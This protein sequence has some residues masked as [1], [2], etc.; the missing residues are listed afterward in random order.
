M[1]TKIAI[2]KTIYTSD[3]ACGEFILDINVQLAKLSAAEKALKEAKEVAV[4]VMLERLEVTGQKH[5]AFDFGTFAKS[6]KTQVSFPT[7]DKGGKERA[8]AW[9]QECLDRGVIEFSDL[10]NVQQARINADPVLAIE[11]AVQ[12]YNESQALIDPNFV[13]ISESPFNHFTQTTLSTPRKK[14]G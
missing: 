7:A 9:L 8:S 2:P 3:K 4:N 11:Q 12:E 14:R 13:P 10:L 5:F 1:S 6:T